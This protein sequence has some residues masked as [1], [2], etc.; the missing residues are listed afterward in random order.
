MAAKAS[1]I[2]SMQWQKDHPERA[3]AAQRRHH[4]KK[5]YGMTVEEFDRL[6]VA[7]NGRCTICGNKFLNSKD[8]NI[9]HDHATGKF[10]GILCSC[11]NRALGYARDS[12]QVLRL[13][14]DYLERWGK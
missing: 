6:L 4:L 7:C 13:M 1:S 12:P 10:R 9:D 2:H 3:R 8:T 11:C 14:A 5:Q